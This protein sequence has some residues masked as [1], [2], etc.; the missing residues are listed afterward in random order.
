MV[1]LDEGREYNEDGARPV[2]QRN[3][4]FVEDT[5]QYKEGE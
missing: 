2:Q 4:A 1:E 3:K 5:D